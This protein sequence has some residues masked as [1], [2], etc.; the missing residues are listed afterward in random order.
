MVEIILQAA[1]RVFVKRGYERATTNR[2]AEEAG[3]SVGSLYQYFPSKD[4][5]AVE[6]LRR[7][8]E[9]L[10]ALVGKY[11]EGATPA[12]VE[13]RV[14]A[15]LAGFLAAEGLNPALHRVLIERVARTAARAEVLGFEDA[16]E[17]VIG[18]MIRAG[19]G[20]D[21]RRDP[22]VSSFVLVR[23][24]LGVI[25]AAVVDRPD[26]DRDAIVDELTRLVMNVVTTATPSR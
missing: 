23:A 26:M 13:P 12:T 22:T 20:E 24:L 21:D 1:A 8:R 4:S 6:L 5:I 3:I 15:M 14:R 25:H 11:L 18:Q 2:I 17:G 9:T 10:F 16:V 7:Y 19:Q